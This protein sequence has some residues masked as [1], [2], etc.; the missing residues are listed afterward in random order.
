MNVVQELPFDSESVPNPVLGCLV[1]CEQCVFI[2]QMLTI[3]QYTFCRGEHRA[4]IGEHL[5]HCLEHFQV[6]LYGLA[7]GRVDYDA[8]ARN[9]E[10]ER[11]PERF[12]G[13]MASVVSVLRTLDSESMHSTVYVRMQVAPESEPSEARSTLARELGFLS[14]H[15]IHHL[16]I[17]KMVAESL[18]IS[19]PK[20]VGVAY[21][22]SAYRAAVGSRL[23]GPTE[24]LTMPR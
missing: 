21:S 22:T 5:R 11:V 14:S 12:I 23:N 8:R 17:I 20:D 16:A 7:A 18:G 15:V 1:A 13:A 4:S 9:E 6:L 10:I 19:L 24:S 2:A 3:E